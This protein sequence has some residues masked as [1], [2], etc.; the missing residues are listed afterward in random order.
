M[1][2]VL[3]SDFEFRLFALKTL[4]MPLVH[5]FGNSDFFTETVSVFHPLANSLEGTI[6]WKLTE[7]KGLRPGSSRTTLSHRT[8]W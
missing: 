7:R 6:L 1:H 5:S 8:D 4:E 3:Q 2:L